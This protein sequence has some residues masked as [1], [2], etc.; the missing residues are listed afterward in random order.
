MIYSVFQLKMVENNLKTC[1][2]PNKIHHFAILFHKNGLC[3]FAEPSIEKR[4]HFFVSRESRFVAEPTAI[5]SLK[6]LSVTHV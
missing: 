4:S 2:N 1:K 6:H 3:K 5:D